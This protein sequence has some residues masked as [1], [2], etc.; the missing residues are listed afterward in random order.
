MNECKK[1]Q[2]MISDYEREL[3]SD[4]DEEDFV[5]HLFSCRDCREEFE[6]HFIIEYGLNDDEI[7]ISPRYQ[8][9]IDCYDF[10]GLVELRLK[11]S[12]QNILH[13]RKARR[14]NKFCVM[15]SDTLLFLVIIIYLIIRFL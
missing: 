13:D 11:D 8:P 10:K 14:L 9:L 15:A 4:R 7:Q 5:S 1:Y 12:Y 6:I 3:L 2:N